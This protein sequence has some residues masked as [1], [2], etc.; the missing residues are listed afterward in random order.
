MP[1]RASV[2]PAELRGVCPSQTGNKP[3]TDAEL[4]SI[5]DATSCV[6]HISR[7]GKD[8]AGK[9]LEDEFYYVP[10]M[11]SDTMGR[12]AVVGGLGKTGL[13]AVRRQHKVSSTELHCQ[14]CQIMLTTLA[15]SNTI[16]N[17]HATSLTVFVFFV[18]FMSIFHICIACLYHGSRSIGRRSRCFAVG[19][20]IASNTVLVL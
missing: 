7:E 8:A 5:L 13:R 9:P 4:R 20:A 15:V 18:R 10:E 19:Q 11:D 12:D 16:G 2:T 1:Q 14:S 3:L 17:V 6:G